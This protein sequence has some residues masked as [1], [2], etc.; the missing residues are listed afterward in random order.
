MRKPEEGAPKN[1]PCG[2]NAGVSPACA[3][4]GLFQAPFAGA[5][6]SRCSAAG[7][8]AGFPG[9]ASGNSCGPANSRGQNS[10][11]QWVPFAQGFTFN[12]FQGCQESGC[13][14]ASG[15]PVPPGG[16]GVDRLVLR[17]ALSPGR[18]ERAICVPANFCPRA[19]VVRS[20]PQ[21]SGP[22]DF[23]TTLDRYP[24]KPVFSAGLRTERP[25]MCKNLAR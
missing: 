5:P 7:W 9:R 12:F 1:R 18:P 25:S 6:R 13:H 23:K 4:A 11:G 22:A 17:S 3:R 15:L 20:R 10:P 16:G 19:Q 21:Q 14:Q 8:M 24:W 2:L